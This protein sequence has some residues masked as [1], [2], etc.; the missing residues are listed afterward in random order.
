MAEASSTKELASTDLNVGK[1]MENL[2]DE[3]LNNATNL[4]NES[5]AELEKQLSQNR[6]VTTAPIA[7]SGQ[8]LIA[9]CDGEVAEHFE[10]CKANF[11]GWGN[12]E[13]G[14]LTTDKYSDLQAQKY[15]NEEDNEAE[16]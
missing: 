2:T 4:I 11:V 14:R 5:I 15:G 13:K 12:D 7:D 8:K 16:N 9:T 1:V 3:V 10:L 6:G